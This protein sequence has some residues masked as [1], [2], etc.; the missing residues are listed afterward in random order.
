MFGKLVKNEFRNTWKLMVIISI[1]LVISHLLMNVLETINGTGMFTGKVFNIVHK[2]YAITYI[3][4]MIG[5]NIVVALHFITRYFRKV[6]SN[7]GYLTHTLPVKKWQITASMLISGFVWSTVTFIVSGLYFVYMEI[8]R[9]TIAG[10][11]VVFDFAKGEDIILVVINLILAGVVFYMTAFL[12]VSIGQNFKSHPTLAS[13]I[14]DVILWF[15]IQ[16]VLAYSIIA[17]ADSTLFGVDTYSPYSY[18]LTESFRRVLWT[19]V[20]GC[21]I[22]SVVFFIANN[23][24]MKKKLN[25]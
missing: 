15:I 12:S 1:A 13:I 11:K 24:I 19:N 9:M 18:T 4:G 25:L 3:L 16:N 6:Y 14:A 8:N 17:I 7:E 22:I 21:L 2:C 20:A 23:Y 5:I 10:V